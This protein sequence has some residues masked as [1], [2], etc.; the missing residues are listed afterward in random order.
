MTGDRPLPTALRTGLAWLAGGED[1]ARKAYEGD[2]SGKPPG[3]V[4]EPSLARLFPDFDHLGQAEGFAAASLRLYAPYR[5]WLD[6]CTT[7]Q[8]WEAHDDG[9]GDSDD[10]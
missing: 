7:V 3:E 9:E 8:A 5:Q 4:E 6:E 2:D 10:D 1:P